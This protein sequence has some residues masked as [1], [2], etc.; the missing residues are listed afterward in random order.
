MSFHPQYECR[1]AISGEEAL[2]ILKSYFPEIILLD[3]MMPGIDGYEVCRRI[4]SQNE[5]KF[6]K[7]IMISGMSMIDDRLKGYDAGA[8]DYLTKP[9][10][11]DELL[12]KLKVY[13][14]LNRM[15]EVDNLKTT[16]M[17]I[18]NH[19]TK[20]PLNGIILGSEL[21]SEMEDLPEKA[22]HYVDFVHESGLRSKSW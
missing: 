7:I 10:V 9:Y 15:E 1:G 14:K 20:T 3:V 17:N 21:L 5:H 22:K 16:A 12:A 4:R 13:S 2:A 18:L 8:D 11:E 19:E 6:A